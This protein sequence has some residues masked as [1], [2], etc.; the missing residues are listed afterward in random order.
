MKSEKLELLK[1]FAYQVLTQN[2]ALGSEGNKDAKRLIR[3]FMRYA[4]SSYTEES[5]ELKAHVPKEAYIEVENLRIPA[6]AYM[7]SPSAQVEGYAKRDF[8][9]GD[10]ALFEGELSSK[11]LEELTK[12]GAKAVIT[13]RQELNVADCWQNYGKG[14]P[15]VSIRRQD[16]KHV[17]GF[18]VRLVVR[19]EE[20][21]LKCSNFILPDIGKGPVIYLTA[22]MDT[23]QEGFGAISN[24]VGFLLLLFIYEELRESYK[25]PYRLR[26]LI[27]DGSCL[28]FAG[29]RHHLSKSPKHVH[30]CIN[31]DGVGWENPCVVYKDAEG[32]NGNRIN[33]LF[34]RHA[35]SM[36]VGINYAS[37]KTFDG[38]HTLF[39]GKGVETLL[40]SSYPFYIRNTEYDLYDAINWDKV[41]MWYELIVSFLRRFHKL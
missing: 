8:L 35:E 32:Y 4:G 14:I 23:P 3:S 11:L 37:V 1:H 25:G 21:L 20:K 7:G 22:R 9:E 13:Y 17:E 29:A 5:F 15:V 28:N 26:F 31:L 30:Y 34:Y 16:L 6:L 38:D 27:T 2:R 39:K 12:A 18:K 19:A 36:G 41:V 10:I 24:G 40:L 33:E